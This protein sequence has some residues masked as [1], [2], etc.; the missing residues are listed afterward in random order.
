MDA[1]SAHSPS[2]SPLD[3]LRTAA[4]AG[5]V[6]LA[7]LW[8]VLVA[9]ATQSRRRGINAMATLFGD[10]GCFLTGIRVEIE[11]ED[12]LTAHRPCVFIFNHQSTV[13]ILIIAR[14]LRRDATA[15]VKR[16]LRNNP[17]FGLPFRW[18][19]VV[20]IDRFDRERAIEAL[21]PV[22]ETLRGGISI[23]VAPEGTRS[24]ERRPGPFKKGAF[25]MAMA[26]GVPIVPI[27]IA[28]TRDLMPK[29]SLVL[30]SGPVH[31]SVGPPIWTEHWSPEELDQRIAEVR[32]LYLAMLGE[33][34][35]ER[36]APAPA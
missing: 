33:P 16:E 29:G 25:R 12:H 15:V 2:A 11:G 9:L 22:V 17:V 4:A 31:V 28:H 26:A 21:R 14:L 34:G 3:P 1:A 19:E 7:L 10:L 6:I 36:P 5:A 18:A 20:F 27:V 23:A 24:L 35:A 32:Q 13:D 30:R 8:G